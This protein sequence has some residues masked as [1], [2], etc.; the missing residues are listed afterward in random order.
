MTQTVDVVVVGAGINGLVAAAELARAG[1]S[2]LVVDGGER[3]GGFIAAEERTLP[4]YVHDTF[5]SWHPLFV[6]SGAYSVLGPELHERGLAYRNTD[7]AVTAAVAE[8]DR[9]AL[10]YRDPE[11]TAAALEVPADRDAYL[12]MLSEMQER[13]GVVF[14]ALGSELR[15][16]AAL[17]LAWKLIRKHRIRGT[18]ALVR[19]SLMSGRS[20]LRGRFRGWE[21]D[22]LWTPWLLHAGLGPDQASGGIMLPVMG[23]SM[24]G[25]GLPV[26][27]GGAGNF[28]SAFERLLADHG[29]ELRLGASVDEI[30]VRDGRAIGVRIGGET[31]LARRAVLASVG[32]QALYGELLAPEHVRPRTRDEVGRYRYGRGA[33]QV[34]VALDRPMRWADGRLDAVPLIHVGNGAASTGIACAQAEA[35]LLPQAP[36][37]VVGQQYVL[38]PSRVPDGK[39][40]LWLQLQEVP[41]APVGDAAGELDTAG[42]WD[43]ALKKAYVER[44]LQRIGRFAPELEA[45]VQ[46]IDIIAPTDLAARNPNA[47][48]GDPYA[49]SAELDQNLLWRPVSSAGGHR[50]SV[51]NLWHIGA[52][53][54]PGPGLGAGSGH[55][56][57]QALLRGKRP[58]AST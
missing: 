14:G 26:V 1:Q 41:Y 56:V 23:L 8:G 36:T 55:L 48:M 4:G 5:S 45:S 54:H 31:V 22:Q 19:Q 30:L 32:P 16:A 52:S 13:A 49:G 53:T 7:E 44:V 15:S 20:Y 42:G 12:L 2:V 34:H 24:H 37:V 43:E 27:A 58:A 29:A 9:V 51:R 3:I 28:L 18:E 21:V 50:T 39:G 33:M 38:D 6:S 46:A 40:A 10:A 11:R 57:A 25:F 35:G 47:V 17:K